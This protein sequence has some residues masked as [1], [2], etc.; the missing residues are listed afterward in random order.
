MNK[1]KHDNLTSQF[2]DEICKCAD[3]TIF[4][5]V[6]RLLNIN[7]LTEE[8]DSQNHFIPKDS[9]LLMVEMAEAFDSKERKKKRELLRIFRKANKEIREDK[10]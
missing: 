4:I 9:N 8:K 2:I 6:A 3:P 5:G 7:L 10:I 1:H